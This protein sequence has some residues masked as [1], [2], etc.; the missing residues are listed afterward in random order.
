MTEVLS[1]LFEQSKQIRPL[2][3]FFL[4]NI[5]FF[6]EVRILKVYVKA[7]LTPL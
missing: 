5:M 2:K 4:D 7:I 6:V 3:I 1:D